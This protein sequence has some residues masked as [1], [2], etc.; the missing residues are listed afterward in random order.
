MTQRSSTD[1]GRRLAEA[2]ADHADWVKRNI[3]ER[4]HAAVHRL[5]E[6]LAAA[7]ADPAIAGSEHVR[8]MVEYLAEVAADRW[9]ELGT[10]NGIQA[11]REVANEQNRRAA[12]RPRKLVTRDDLI[13][14][15]DAFVARHGTER[16]WK[17]GAAAHFGVS[18]KVIGK[19]LSDD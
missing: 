3:G 6:I 5:A 7:V 18:A 9:V 4:E 14:F 13:A 10:G 16:G 12:T 17:T 15:R 2:L 1:A 19:R 11:L 8:L